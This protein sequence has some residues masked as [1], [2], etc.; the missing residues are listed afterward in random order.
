MFSFDL[1]ISEKYFTATCSE[2]KF[3]NKNKESNNDANG[4]KVLLN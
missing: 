1:I 3:P 4:W 2:A